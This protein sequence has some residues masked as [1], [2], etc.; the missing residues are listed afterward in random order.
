VK[1][2][3]GERS[4][5]APR[6][7]QRA[8]GERS[9]VGAEP[10]LPE[11]R[12]L[13]SLRR[14][15]AVCRGCPLYAHATQTVFGDGRQRARIVLVGEAPGDAEDLKGHPFVGP[16]G[17]LLDR[18]LAD[19]GIERTA[20]YVT[21]VVKHFKWEPRGKRRLHRTPSPAEVRA[22]LP[23]LEAEIDAVQ[24]QLVV[25]LGATAARALLGHGFSLT[26]QRGAILDAGRGPWL[27][28]TFH[29][30]AIL[31]RRGE[32]ERRAELERLVDDLRR[33]RRALR[34]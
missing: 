24:P 31:R 4:Q 15:A 28:A 8:E 22:C 19:A 1:R 2:A 13:A 32:A 23:W 6:R 12:S 18:A 20:C 33:M 14:A 34:D 16:A 29:P 10:Y 27:A 26:R 17:Q 7:A 25:A 5:Q 11:R 21:N 9:Q 30:S 3:E